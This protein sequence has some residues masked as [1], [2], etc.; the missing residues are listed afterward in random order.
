MCRYEVI[1]INKVLHGMYI[2]EVHVDD[3]VCEDLVLNTDN[4]TTG[5]YYKN[6]KIYQVINYKMNNTFEIKKKKP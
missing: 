1:Y 6:A 5:S 4:L 3:N 2:C